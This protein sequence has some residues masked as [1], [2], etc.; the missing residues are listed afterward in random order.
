MKRRLKG[1]ARYFPGCLYGLLLMIPLSVVIG[2]WW[3]EHSVQL[4]VKS[5]A[6]ILFIAFY[7]ICC[8]AGKKIFDF[9]E[10]K[11]SKCKKNRKKAQ[12]FAKLTEVAVFFGVILLFIFVPLLVEVYNENSLSVSES[13]NSWD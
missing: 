2:I 1:A 3:S 10:R 11:F 13:I 5:I 7:L 6:L 8:K 12:F 4:W 9:T